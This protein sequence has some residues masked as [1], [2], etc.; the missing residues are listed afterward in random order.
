MLDRLTELT[1]ALEIWINK[2]LRMTTGELLLA[3][4][5][6]GSIVESWLRHFYTAYNND[7]KSNP[8]KSK[9]KT[10]KNS[11]KEASFDDLQKYSIGIL[12]KN[13][14]DR[15]YQWVDSI[16][17]KRNAVHS[18]LR[19]ELG[20]PQNFINDIDYLKDFI[21]LIV[22]HLPPVLDCLETIPAGYI[23]IDE[24]FLL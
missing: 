7:Y 8:I 3:Y 10:T 5:N 24:Y 22:E 2:G 11:W 17:D 12:W 1:D 18:Y 16:R 14:N 13:K 9:N 23:D 4:V 20:T 19:K 6:L 15:L 21:K